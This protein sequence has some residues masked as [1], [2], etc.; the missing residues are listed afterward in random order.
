MNK[1]QYENVER[2][3]PQ[4]ELAKTGFVRISRGD[5]DI[6]RR[7]YNDVFQKDLKP[8]NMN[9]NACVLKMMK[10]MGKAVEKYEESQTPEAQFAD[11]M[12]TF[13]TAAAEIEEDKAAAIKKKRQENMAKARA[14][15]EAK[16]KSE[17]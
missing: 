17:S 4:F 2:F 13:N 8:S 10:E 12:E 14:A 5:L 6:I 15:R 9:C 7:T 1:Q 16:K 11:A 3:K